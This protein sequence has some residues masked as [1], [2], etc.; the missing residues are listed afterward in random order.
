MIQRG[1]MKGVIGLAREEVPPVAAGVG[2]R[3]L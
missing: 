1:Y 2:P 3:P